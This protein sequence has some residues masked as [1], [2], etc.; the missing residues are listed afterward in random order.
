MKYTRFEETPLCGKHTIQDIK[1]RRGKDGR[2]IIVDLSDSGA[3]IDVK[4]QGGRLNVDLMPAPDI[5]ANLL[6]NL[7][8]W[9]LGPPF[10]LLRQLHKMGWSSLLCL[11]R[12]LG[13]IM[14]ISQKINSLSKLK[15]VE[16]PNKL[17][18]GTKI[19]Y[20]GPRVSIN[21]QNGDIRSLLRLMAEELNLNAVISESVSGT[22][23]LVLKDVP[24]DQVVDII[25][26]QKGLDM[27]KNGNVILLRHEMKLQ[28]EKA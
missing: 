21:Y 20:Q 23:T 11:R 7:M 2:R 16:D 14:P 5:S 25:F 17:T 9:I 6:R 26:Q 28:R 3:G 24:A 4:Q 19:G 22:T 10:N 15:I 27:R 1:F 18:Q 13:N 12:H 8:L